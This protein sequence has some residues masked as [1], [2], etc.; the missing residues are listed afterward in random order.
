MW[1][2]PSTRRRLA[3]LLDIPPEYVDDAMGNDI[4]QAW[5]NNN[6]AMEGI[7][8]DKDG[9][10]HVDDW[11]I[12][13]MRWGEFNQIVEYPLANA[14]VDTV[15]AYEFPR[16]RIENLLANMTPVME[17]KGEYFTGVD[18]SPCAFEMYWRLRGLEETMLE[19]AEQ[20]D[21]AYTMLGRCADFAVA[22]AQEACARF[23][24]DW[25]W[26]GDDVAGQQS[27]FIS[28]DSWRRLIKPHLQRVVDV[29]T[30]NRLPVAFHSCGAIR[31]VIE[32]LVEMGIT[33]LNPIQC[34]CAGME[35]ADLKRDF[36]ADLV[37]VG[38][39]DTQELLPYATADDVRRATTQLIEVMTS[40]GGGYI[41]A[42][43]HTVPPE[44]PEANLFAMYDAA[45]MG[46]E[47]IFDRAAGI[48]R[49]LRTV[50][51]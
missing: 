23:D 42:A 1:F 35:P 29:G 50:Q 15:L 33:V 14:D 39:V 27:M 12:K 45:G 34:N 46:K 8:H 37:F 19:I 17:A 40:D 25:L 2:Q 28:P 5:V 10:W 47:Q 6:Y 26:T 21:L 24:V 18:V 22:L 20:S 30:A 48:R 31:P 9:E 7:V 41:L 4:R 44:T 32:D 43:S 3:A 49:K 16:D 11:G 13:W 51:S 36:G 38:G